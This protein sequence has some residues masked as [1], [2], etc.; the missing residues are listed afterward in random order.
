MLSVFRQKLDDDDD[1]LKARVQLDYDI[2][3]AAWTPACSCTQAAERVGNAVMK[4]F[5]H[6][7]RHAWPKMCLRSH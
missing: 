6:T 1:A 3:S 4:A 2:V 5:V 7:T